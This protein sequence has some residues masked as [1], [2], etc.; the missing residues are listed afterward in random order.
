MNWKNIIADIQKVGKLTQAQIGL[1]CGTKQSTINS[2]YSGSSAQP[3]YP[4]GVKLTELH[5]KTMRKPRTTAGA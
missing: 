4:L 3:A 2:L 1:A 5:K